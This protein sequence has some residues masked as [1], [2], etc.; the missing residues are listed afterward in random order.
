MATRGRAARRPAPRRVAR[1]SS[2]RRRGTRRSLVDFQAVVQEGSVRGG[3]RR[4]RRC[5]GGE[6]DGEVEFVNARLAPSRPWTGDVTATAKTSFRRD[7][8]RSVRVGLAAQRC[9]EWLVAK[10]AAR[11]RRDLVRVDVEVGLQATLS[12]RSA[13]RR[14]AGVLAEQPI[15]VVGASWSS[16]SRISRCC[17]CWCFFLRFVP[18]VG[19]ICTVP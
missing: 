9:A 13:G 19:T 10:K 5:R 2:R 18:S 4:S 3:E 12:T 6:R 14:A 8:P 1:A 16:S 15:F 17:S 11:S 7:P